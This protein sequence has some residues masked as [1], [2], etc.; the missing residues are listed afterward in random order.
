MGGRS[1]AQLDGL[2]AES[3]VSPSDVAGTGRG[4]DSPLSHRTPSTTRA[5]AA[6]KSRHRN[7]VTDTGTKLLPVLAGTAMPYVLV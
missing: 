7:D 4:D 3:T 1:V 2:P 6:E 5:I